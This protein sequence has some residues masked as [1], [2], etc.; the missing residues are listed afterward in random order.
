MSIDL[1][2]ALI[3]FAFVMT[4]TPGP[5]NLML[6]ASGVNYGFRRTIPHMLGIVGGVMLMIAI[7]GLGLGKIFETY[8]VAYA[9]LRIVGGLYMLWL[10]WK[11]ANSGP[12]TSGTE[13]SRPMTFLQAALFQWVNPKAWVMVVSAIATYSLP[14]NYLWTI[15]II[16]LTFGAVGLPSISVWPLFG[17]GLKQFLS[18][19]TTLRIFNVAMAALLAASLWPLLRH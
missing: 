15:T 1:F 13:R 12:I 19:P 4:V 17:M 16:V 9:G 3:A 10:A 7:M 18:D 6:L 8:P 5:N 11:I 2:I 14:N